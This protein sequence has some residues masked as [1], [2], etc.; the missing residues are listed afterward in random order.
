M[1][2]YI[3]KKIYEANRWL[4]DWRFQLHQNKLERVDPKFNPKKVKSFS[5]SSKTFYIDK[6]D[7][8]AHFVGHSKLKE[9]DIDDFIKENR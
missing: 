2:D 7:R 6:Y 1:Q 8:T 5:V 4:N 3:Q 9:L